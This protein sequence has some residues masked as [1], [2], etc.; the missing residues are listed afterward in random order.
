MDSGT[1]TVSSR[2][3]SSFLGSF[4]RFLQSHFIRKATLAGCCSSFT[5][6]IEILCFLVSE[7]SISRPPLL[8]LRV[9]SLMDGTGSETYVNSTTRS[10]VLSMLVVALSSLYQERV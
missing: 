5:A 1:Y 8:I 6:G 3:K 10:M 2:T 9:C 7:K 4:I